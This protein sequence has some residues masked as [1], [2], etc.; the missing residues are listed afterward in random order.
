MSYLSCHKLLQVPDLVIF[1]AQ[2][3]AEKLPGTREED[4]MRIYLAAVDDQLTMLMQDY[5]AELDESLF[6]LGKKHGAA[7]REESALASPSE[8]AA[9]ALGGGS[10]GI[11]AAFHLQALDEEAVQGQGPQGDVKLLMWPGPP[12]WLLAN[13]GLPRHLTPILRQSLSSS[14]GNS[15]RD[16]SRHTSVAQFVM[17]SRLKRRLTPAQASWLLYLTRCN[18]QVTLKLAAAWSASSS[19]RLSSSISTG[20]KASRT[21]GGAGAGGGEWKVTEISG[22]ARKGIERASSSCLDLI[23]KVTTRLGERCVEVIL[24]LQRGGPMQLSTELAI[25]DLAHSWQQKVRSGCPMDSLNG[26]PS[27]SPSPIG[28]EGSLYFGLGEY[29]RSLAVML[30]EAPVLLLKQED[31]RVGCKS[32]EGQPSTSLPGRLQSIITSAMHSYSSMLAI[33][34][35]VNPTPPPADSWVP[36]QDGFFSSFEAYCTAA[37]DTMLT[38]TSSPLETNAA[39]NKRDQSKQN[40]EDVAE[41]GGE[42]EALKAGSKPVGQLGDGGKAGGREGRENLTVGQ[43]DGFDNV[44]YRGSMKD[45]LGVDSNLEGLGST[46]TPSQRGGR[47]LIVMSNATMLRTTILPSTVEMHRAL[48]VGPSSGRS[49]G[50]VKAKEAA[51][52]ASDALGS[53]VSDLLESFIDIQEE[54]VEEIVTSYLSPINPSVFQAAMTNHWVEEDSKGQ[55]QPRLTKGLHSIYAHLLK[56]HTQVFAFSPPMTMQPVWETLV[57]SLDSSL[58]RGYAGLEVGSTSM[59]RMMDLLL[60][61]EYLECMWTPVASG[62]RGGRQ[63]RGKKDRYAPLSPSGHFEAAFSALGQ[64]M[65]TVAATRGPGGKGRG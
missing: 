55:R 15:S 14:A 53:L 9:K 63:V 10:R 28:L 1:L 49:K 6:E 22:L 4:P 60:D 2:L 36:I 38:S 39:K 11:K 27:S 13:V 12:D 7:L 31:W 25:A 46:M 20:A 52:V 56:V 23:K 44:L 21:E 30:K 59:G 61:L 18:Q 19:Q 41:E 24:A 42:L 5:E 47:L 26:P 32:R 37:R 17:G 65:I 43:G 29:A 45:V 8:K 62:P 57:E 34:S 58:Q 40:L 48:I 50:D 16:V 33:V 54:R 3:V 64:A 51:K 35:K